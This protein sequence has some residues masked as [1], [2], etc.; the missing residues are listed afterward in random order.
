MNTGTKGQADFLDF[1]DT[2]VVVKRE[3]VGRELYPSQ[4]TVEELDAQ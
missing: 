1:F 2:G 4:V 3:K